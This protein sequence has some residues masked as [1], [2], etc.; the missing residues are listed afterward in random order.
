[1]KN[2]AVSA[3]ET[4]PNRKKLSYLG[5]LSPNPWDLPLYRQNGTSLWGGW[6]RP[7]IPAAGS[8]LRWHPCV[9]LSSAQVRSV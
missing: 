6:C 4:Q 7:A 9:A 2:L 3:P 5:T 1:M 8:A